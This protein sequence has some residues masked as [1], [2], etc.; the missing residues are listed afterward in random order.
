DSENLSKLLLVKADDKEV[1][2]ERVKLKETERL[3]GSFT[4]AEIS[5][6][7]SSS[8]AIISS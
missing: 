6:L 4:T 3:V 1:A 8:F 5:T 7:E 2:E